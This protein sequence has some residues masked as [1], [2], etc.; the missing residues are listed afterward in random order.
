MRED[1]N[2]HWRSG[3]LPV[4]RPARVVAAALEVRNDAPNRPRL[5]HGRD[6]SHLTAAARAAFHPILLDLGARSSRPCRRSLIGTAA[7][8]LSH[9]HPQLAV[10]KSAHRFERP[11]LSPATV[12]TV[13]SSIQVRRSLAQSIDTKRS[14]VSIPMERFAIH[15]RDVR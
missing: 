1:Q 13:S 5:D 2:S 12:A 8:T 3:S 15:S 10:R 6:D 4:D 14:T 11:L 9:S 7:Q